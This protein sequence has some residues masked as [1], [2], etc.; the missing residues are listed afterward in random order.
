MR[1]VICAVVLSAVSVTACSR[2]QSESVPAPQQGLD[3]QP[4]PAGPQTST[5]TAGTDIATL[6]LLADQGDQ[7]AQYLI[8][9]RYQYGEGVEPA[10]TQAVAWYQKAADQGHA[11]AQSYLAAMYADGEGVPQDDAQAVAWYRKAADQGYAAAARFWVVPM[12]LL[13]VTSCASPM[14]PAGLTSK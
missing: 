2:Q 14:A 11:E 10:T 8:G 5:A 13:A 12:P 9:L 4:T 7:E 1:V 6:R 3:G